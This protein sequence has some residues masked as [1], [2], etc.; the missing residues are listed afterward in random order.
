MLQIARAE[1]DPELWGQGPAV[2]FRVHHDGVSQLLRMRRPQ[3]HGESGVVTHAC[4]I[5]EDVDDLPIALLQCSLQE[6]NTVDG[7]GMT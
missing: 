5:E 6:H 2:D 3:D 1:H 7:R 4:G